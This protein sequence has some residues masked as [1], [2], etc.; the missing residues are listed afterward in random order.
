ME[1]NLAEV[2]IDSLD[3]MVMMMY[4]CE[5]YGVDDAVSKEWHPETVGEIYN[6][7]EANKSREPSSVEGAL[8]QIIK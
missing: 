5:L 3:G 8:E 2:G 4:L 6:L 1:D 7:L